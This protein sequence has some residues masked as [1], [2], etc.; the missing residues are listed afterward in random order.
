MKISKNELTA[1]L[2]KAFEG[3]GFGVGDYE[4]AAGM[5]TWLETHGLQGLAQLHAALPHLIEKPYLQI[6]LSQEDDRLAVLDA[7]GGSTLIC[8]GQAV[9]MAY[10]KAR[11]MDFGIV[12]LINCHNRK[13]I[14]ERLVNTARR[15]MAC[16]A[17]WR[18]S[19]GPTAFTL[20]SID[21]HAE[22][23][24][25]VEYTT[26]DCD[27]ENKQSMVFLCGANLSVLQE[28]VADFLPVS[29]D[30][31]ASATPEAMESSYKQAL[32]RGIEM[33]LALWESLEKLINNV[34]VEATE[35][36]RAGAGE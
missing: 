35:T 6:E 15:G 10:T 28:Y 2:K 23:P 31:V 27:A 9:D 34:L 18:S 30:S 16:M 33:D 22:Y 12:Q 3:I 25:C 5:V 11:N 29:S 21:A 13:M 8:G 20:V 7:Q 4:D 14:I 26:Q 32:E 24:N 1:A 17:Y 36:S 19:G